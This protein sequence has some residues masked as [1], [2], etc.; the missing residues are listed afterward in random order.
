LTFPSLRAASV[1]SRVM[2]VGSG[3]AA[4]SGEMRRPA[5]MPVAALITSRLERTAFSVSNTRETPHTPKILL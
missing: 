4:F 2:A 3:V 1:N 5:P